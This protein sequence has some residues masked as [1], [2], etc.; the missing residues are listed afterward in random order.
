ML[1]NDST[2]ITAQ[3]AAW[4]DDFP[5]HAQAVDAIAA[6]GEAAIPALRAYVAGDPQAIPQARCFAV[7]MLARF[8]ADTAT[9]ALR[10]VLRLHPLKALAPPYAESEYVV[11]SEA[12]QALCRRSCPQLADDIAIAVHERLRVGVRAVGTH[13]LAGLADAVVDV[14]DDDVLAEAAAG[15]LALV[16]SASTTAIM[17]RLDAWLAEAEWSAR[18]RLALLRALRVL[19]GLH[20]RLGPGV[21]THALAAVHPAV[22]A[23]AALLAWPGRRDPVVTEALLRG[24]VGCD[25]D[26]A[27]LC[28]AA[29]EQAGPDLPGS[30]RQAL[31]RN[32]EPD[33]Y[34]E[35][36]PLSAAQRDWLERRLRA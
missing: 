3:V 31:R 32:A 4:I 12:L 21:S 28:R 2:D 5:G 7:A 16:G 13:G 14:L 11:K 6:L 34:G 25:R 17:P 8:D 19:H 35:L 36:H 30:A 29:S 33:I 9:S 27:D 18:R 24:A 22:R 1:S 23:A 20:A 26:L 15:A 10:A